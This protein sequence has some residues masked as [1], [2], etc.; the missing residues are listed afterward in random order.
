[1]KGEKFEKECETVLLKLKQTQEQNMSC[2][3]CEII[4]LRKFRQ[5]SL[6]K[7][8]FLFALFLKKFSMLERIVA[9][10]HKKWNFI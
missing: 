6:P 9:E 3:Q 5:L 10:C 4:S 1:M 8:H 7:I 2:R